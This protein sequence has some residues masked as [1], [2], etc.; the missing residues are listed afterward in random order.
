MGEGPRRR[1]ARSRRLRAAPRA[2][3]GST[4]VPLGVRGDQEGVWARPAQLGCLLPAGPV[5]MVRRLGS[6]EW[7]GGVSARRFGER[8]RRLLWGGLSRDRRRSRQ[9][10]R[11]YDDVGPES[12]GPSSADR[13]RRGL[14]RPAAVVARVVP[15]G[16]L[17]GA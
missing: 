10:P 2:R 5:R 16:G 11:S 14:A 12:A 15:G 4:G 9:G 6:A 17:I 7:R 13:A 3:R 1:A 8:D